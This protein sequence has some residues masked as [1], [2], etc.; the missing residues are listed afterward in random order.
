MKFKGIFLSIMM[1]LSSGC[2]K[3]T[4]DEERVDTSQRES[5]LISF[6]DCGGQIGDNPCDF[7]FKDQ[8]GD[9][10]QLYKNHGKII[11]LDFST[12]WCGYCQISAQKA[13]EIQKK[14]SSSNFVWVTILIEDSYGAEPDQ[15]DL[16]QWASSFSI[17]D[18]SILM[19]NRSIIDSSGKNGFPVTAWPTFIII[20]ENMTIKSGLRGWSEQIII[21]LIE[22]ELD[23]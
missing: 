9:D 5:E 10:W 4:S 3:D 22:N 18:S 12:M 8:N 20:D 15:D 14:Y 21:E 19:G 2:H 11:L 7:S 13:E 23:S 17:E 16:A 1:I 6:D